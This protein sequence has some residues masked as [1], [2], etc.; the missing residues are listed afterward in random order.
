MA[1]QSVIF[2][3]RADLLRRKVGKRSCRFRRRRCDGRIVARLIAFSQ[4]R[5]CRQT[6]DSLCR[7]I[8]CFLRL[9]TERTF[10]ACCVLT[11]CDFLGLANEKVFQLACV[12]NGRKYDEYG[13]FTA[14][15]PNA[16]IHV[17]CQG[18]RC[19]STKDC[20]AARLSTVKVRLSVA[21]SFLNCHGLIDV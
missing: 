9:E 11:R 21:F 4:Q 3:L 10:Y 19:L 16:I 18:P 13:G 17:S 5:R 7:R 15:R 6:N 8:A 20:R 2:H 1:S 14:Y 12:Q